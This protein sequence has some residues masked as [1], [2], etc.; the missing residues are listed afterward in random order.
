MTTVISG[1][2]V[3]TYS[4][5]PTAL[6]VGKDS[7]R[8]RWEVRSVRLNEG[9]KKLEHAC[10]MEIGIRELV[11]ASTTREVGPLAFRESSLQ[12]ADLSAV[13]GWIHLG[14]YAFS[15][16]KK[17]KQVVIGAGLEVISQECFYMTG[18]EE[19]V[20]PRNVRVI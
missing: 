16:C 3:R 10:F 5:P 8:G 17:L 4:L 13:Y 6:V 2:S 12:R 9:L 1:R 19:M 7:F 18:L 11:L 20:I 15:Q 14:S